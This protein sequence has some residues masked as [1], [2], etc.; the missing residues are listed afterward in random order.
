MGA[1]DQVTPEVAR[2]LGVLQETMSRHEL[3]QALGLKDEKH[4]RQQ[5]QQAAIAQ[6]LV[7]MTLPDKPRSSKQRYRLTA[8]GLRLKARGAGV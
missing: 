8:A 1:S 3:M 5:Y 6:G 2:L 7:E 4:F